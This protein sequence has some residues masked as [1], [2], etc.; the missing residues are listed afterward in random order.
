MRKNGNGNTV[1]ADEIEYQGW[2]K[3]IRLCNGTVQLLIVT[4]VG[5]RILFFGFQGERNEF[6]EN[7]EHAGMSGGGDYCVYGGHRLWVSPEV[8]STYYP[9]NGPVSVHMD[10]DVFSFTAPPESHPETDLQKEI[11]LKL[12]A[13]GTHVSVT[14]RI[15]N[16]GKKAAEIAPWALS[17]MAGG[18]KAIL[19]LPPRAAPTRSRLLPEGVFALWSWTDLADPRWKFSTNYVQLKQDSDPRSTFKEQMG[20]IYNPFGWGAYF[21]ESHLFIK[22]ARVFNGARYPDFGCN[23]ELYTDPSSLEIE[24]LGPLQILAPEQTAEHREDWW[25]F[26]DLP[27]GEDDK[28]IGDV[29]LKMVESTGADA[30]V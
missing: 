26:R 6:Y 8:E 15:R 25:L 18:G 2:K 20:G 16:V 7:P 30:Q 23:F 3:V 5:P 17:V 13:N 4:E 29:I 27:A 9:D 11:E 19:P 1:K 28:W 10:K 12:A 21:R 22:K 24:T 14:H